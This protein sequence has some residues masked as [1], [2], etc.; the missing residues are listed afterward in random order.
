MSIIFTT[1]VLVVLVSMWL[2]GAD[3]LKSQ[4]RGFFI[5][6]WIGGT[7]ACLLA[8]FT[9]LLF[10]ADAWYWNLAGFALT[11]MSMNALVQLIK[12]EKA[13]YELNI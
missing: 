8:I 13:R 9:S 12:R 3:R 10:Y 5:Q 1:A 4:G 6:H 7:V 2:V 11:G